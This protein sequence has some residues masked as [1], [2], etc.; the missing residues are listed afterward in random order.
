V[1]LPLPHA[2]DIPF[3]VNGWLWRTGIGA[4]IPSMLAYVVG[5]LGGF[6]LVRGLASRTAAWI[7]API[8]ALNPNLLYM[9]ATAL[10]EALYFACFIWTAVYFS[11][12]ARQAKDNPL[13]ARRS[14]EKCALVLAAA[15]LVRYDAW[16]LAAVVATGA[17]VILWKQAN[18]APP[19][20]RGLVNFLLL[21]ALVPG[22]WL[23]YNH[24]A[25]GNALEFA[26]GPYSA[27]AIQERTR[28]AT[29]PSYPGENS[30]RTA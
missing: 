12:F 17:T 7:A 25:Y 19:L 1:W 15:M 4:A 9:Q 23:A 28:T 6:P 10:A 14:L 20:R 29:M 18:P 30:P 24:A 3:I 2:L 8:Y 22:V 16:L 13:R 26:N 11:E 27:R 5:T 21:T